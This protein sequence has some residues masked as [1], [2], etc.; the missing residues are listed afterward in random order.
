MTFSGDGNYVYYVTA[1]KNESQAL[2]FQVPVLGGTPRKLVED[3]DDPVALSP[4]GNQIAFARFYPPRGTDDLTL[5]KADGSDQHVVA[6]RKLPTRY[7][8]SWFGNSA[9][10]AWSPDGRTIATLA[11]EGM[12][13]AQWSLVGVPVAGGAEKTISPNKWSSSG[14]VAW[15]GDGSGLVLDASDQSSSLLP[16]LWYVAYPSGEARRITNDLNRYFGVSLTGDSSALVTVQSE[17]ASSIWVAPHGDATAARRLTSGSG[18]GEGLNG[19]ASVPNGGVLYTSNAGGHSDIWSM[20]ADGGNPAQLTM[21]AGNNTDPAVSADGR[22][23]VFSSDRNGNRNIWSMN[24]DGSSPRQLTNGNAD[25]LPQLTPDGK[26][27]LYQSNSAGKLRTCK[28]PLNGGTPQPLIERTAT[29]PTISPDGK[30]VAIY[31]FDEAAGR[32]EIAYMPIEGGEPAKLSYQVDAAYGWSPDS[33]ALLYVDNRNGVSN[34]MSQTLDGRPP[35]Q[36][37]N[38]TE[39]TIFNFAWSADGKQLF[40]ARG[41]INSDVVLINNV[42]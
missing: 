40:L 37:T 42:K 2:L 8:S 36:I 11:A 33:K 27:L 34:L 32:F 41:A 9:G 3:I 12:G 39:G 25:F 30:W 14:R 31:A 16:Q 13:A 10:L 7:A 6:S 24:I 38:F 17:V 15:L 5:A 19:V 29:N 21:N 28:Q 26:W 1:A 20:S 35:K 18:T 23:V 22:I 4:D